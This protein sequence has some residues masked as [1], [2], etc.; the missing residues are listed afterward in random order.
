MSRSEN[1]TFVIV[2]D[3]EIAVMG[4]KRSLSKLGMK[5]PIAVAGDGREALD[6]L[7]AESSG[8]KRPYVILLDLNMPRMGGLEFLERLR[9][10]RELSDC[11]VFVLTTSD[12]PEDIAAAYAK[13]VAGYIVKL[14]TA[15]NEMTLLSMLDAYT[16]VVR[17]N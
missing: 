17:L 3:D 7:R 15:A 12:A 11:V 16:D 8:V 13:K 2:D 6:L 5:N 4:L 10:D 1:V 9:E 14:E